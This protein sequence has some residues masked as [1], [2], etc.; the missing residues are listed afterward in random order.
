VKFAVLVV[1]FAAVACAKSTRESGKSVNARP[2]SAVKAGDC[3]EARRRAT[4]E[5]GL[6]VD[7]LPA[8][9]KQTPIFV[10]TPPSVQAKMDKKGMSV[11]VDVVVD[12][13]GKAVM[14]TFKVRETS[15]P[16]FP[17][18]LKALM[19][20]WTFSPAQLAGCK[21]E[22]IYK[23]SASAKPKASP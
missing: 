22:R 14:R 17:K 9:L 13:L 15:D 20:W 21:V 16:W 2:M 23:F 6:A 18:N 1:F 4:A 3:V 19:P 5:P 10:P 7:Q 8:V 12:T 11:K